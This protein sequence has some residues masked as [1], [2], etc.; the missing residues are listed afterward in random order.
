MASSCYGGKLRMRVAEEGPEFEYPLPIP[1]VVIEAY[2]D[3]YD[4]KVL[5]GGYKDSAVIVRDKSIVEYTKSAHYEFLTED[6]T[7]NITWVDGR[8]SPNEGCWEGK[9]LYGHRLVPM[10]SVVEYDLNSL[11][12]RIYNVIP[13]VTSEFNWL[14]VD[15]IMELYGEEE[16]CR[17]FT[18]RDR[19]VQKRVYEGN[20]NTK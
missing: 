5:V 11:V 1:K 6:E 10:Y 9:D 7:G 2:G 4:P 16:F 13:A 18:I 15:R 14:D 20:D 12:K 3:D 19:K 17:D 8:T